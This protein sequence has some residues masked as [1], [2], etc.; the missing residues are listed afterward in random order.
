[1]FSINYHINWCKPI[2]WLRYILIFLISVSFT[3]NLQ[4]QNFPF[5]EYSVLDGLPQSQVTW[6]FQES[7]GFLWIATR[8]GLSRFD[9]VEFVNYFRKNGLPSNFVNN[10]F[11][12]NFGNIWT[13]S[14]EGFSLYNGSGF[15]FKPLP[16]ELNGWKFTSGFTVDDNNNF[17]VLGFDQGDTKRKLI[18][19]KNDNYS[20][21]SKQ[22]PDLDTMNIT[23]FIFNHLANEMLILNDHNKLWLWKDSTLSALSP[24]KIQEI[25]QDRGNILALSNDVFYKYADNKLEALKI[26]SVI[27]RSEALNK[28]STQSSEIEFFDGRFSQNISLPFNCIGFSFDNE[29]GIWFPSEK[30]LYHLLST[31]FCSFNEDDIGTRNIWA[32]AEDRNGKIFFGSL[33]GTLIEFDGNHFRERT[34]FKKLFGKGLGFYKGSRKMLNGDIWFS[35]NNGVLIWDGN[36]F[37]RLKEIPDKT[38]ICYIYEDPDNK[39][40]ML[41]TEKGLFIIKRGK[42]SLLADFVDSNL[43]VI[44]GV[45]KDDSGVY[46]LSGH[47]GIVRFDGIN[48]VPVREDILADGYTYTIEKDN[49]GG[50]WV[51]SE[52]GLYFRGKNAEKFINGLP[53]I[54]NRPAN[55][56]AIIDSTHI[57]VGR[58]SDICIIDLKSFYRNEKN[59]FRIYDKS[60]GF[61]GNDCLDNGIIRDRQNRFWILTSNRVVILD[62]EKLKL[63]PSP[64]KILITGFYYQTDSLEWK[65]IE[66]AGFFYR[67]PENLRL[68]RN[69][70][71]VQI[72]F[73]GISPTNP[74][75]VLLQYRLVGF[76]DNWSQ[77]SNKRFVVYEQLPPGDYTFQLMGINADGVESYKP[78]SMEFRVLPSLLQR[79]WIQISALVLSL[80]ITVIFTLIVMKRRQRK[81]EDVKHLT[82][83]LTRLQMSSVLKQFDPHFTFNVISSVGSLIM[84]GE[85]EIAYDYIT[86]L[87]SLLRVVLS[88]G[89]AVIMPISEEINFVRKYCELQKLRFKERFSFSI[90][91]DENVDSQRE[92]PKM[93]IQTFVENSIKHGF[94][95]RKE[96]GELKIV[97][98]NED[99]KLVIIILDNGI[100]RVAAKAQKT[101]GTGHGLKIVKSLFDYMNSNNKK[102]STVKITDLEENGKPSGTEVKISIP[103]DYRFGFEKG[104][105]EKLKLR[106]S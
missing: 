63:N 72:T 104:R 91:I 64:P 6:F 38:Q 82:F 83:E 31:A 48:S 56:I 3:N 106:N 10:I 93:I 101:I 33:Y 32:L 34:D 89:S 59:Y 2:N 51:T 28:M 9:G 62:P 50:L 100:G 77:P 42:V 53:E 80:F 58:V 97:I 69:Q 55:S 60:D 105:N 37:S 87:S 61:D 84:K 103:D 47:R 1:M 7:N 66:K 79:T 57:L 92:V 54:F 29:N 86:K 76:D 36:K 71:K 90:T 41:G 65:P 26:N 11:E 25:Y 95:N 98:R 78:L 73:I 39:D 35:T 24:L 4:S 21:Y 18:I 75:R 23:M 74:E 13:L 12:D 67:I 14:N 68:K 43:G 85:K 94:E 20:D 8:N 30:N 88:D 44:E 16:P 49:H 96:G 46:W 45:T 99:N 15:D 17:F 40:V 81:K 52:E 22:Y 5:R 70:N 27:G 19:F 102:I